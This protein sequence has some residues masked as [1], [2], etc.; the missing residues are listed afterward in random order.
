MKSSMSTQLTPRDH[1]AMFA[2]KNLYRLDGKRPDLHEAFLESTQ[3]WGPEALRVW[4]SARLRELLTHAY[5]RVPFYRSRIDAAGGVER[6]LEDDGFAALPLLTK[7]DMR[8]HAP[9][10]LTESPRGLVAGMT[11]GTT[12][13]P[14]RVWHDDSFTSWLR[15]L[16][17]RAFLWFGVEPTQPSFYFGG[18]PHTLLGKAKQRVIDYSIVRRCA[19][20]YDMSPKAL[21]RVINQ[22]RRFRPRWVSGFPS[23]LYPLVLRAEETSV[24]LH[25]LGIRL[26]LPVSEIT[27]P[28]FR[29]AFQRVFGAPILLEYGCV[30]IGAMAFSCPAGSLHIS[31]EHV[32][33]EVLGRDGRP[34]APG[35]VGRVVLTPLVAKTMPLLRYE[36]GDL[37]RLEVGPCPCGR[38]PGMP[39]IAQ[40]EGRSFDEMFDA[41]GRA[42]HAFIVYYAL[43][44]V[45]DPRVFREFQCVQERKGE[46]RLLIV[47]GASFEPAIADKLAAAVKVKVGGPLEVKWEKVDQIDREGSGKFKY[48]KSTVRARP[49]G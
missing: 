23:A 1:F 41:D 6:C 8:H 48:F 37:A 43:K 44:E 16:Q 25:D 12:G 36:L 31:H 27:P 20:C 7:D 17:R 14:I 49:A 15:A 46:L 29:E 2:A 18:P 11:S 24:P 34:V 9:E 32:V 26:V 33:F 22:L 39:W 13:A 10:L 42:W 5:A 4:R 21:D 38:Y 45:F 40:M 35:E 30:E 47:P 3:W 19:V 28:G